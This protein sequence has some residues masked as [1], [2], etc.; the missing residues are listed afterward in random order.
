MADRR[1]DLAARLAAL[2]EAVEVADGRVDADLVAQARA[3]GDKARERLS[4]GPR[5]VVVALGGGTG[6]GKSS[7]FNALAGAALARTGAVRPVTAEATAWVVGESGDADGLLEWLGVPRRHHVEAGPGAPDGL[8]LL[9]LPDHDSV[10][11]GHRLIVDRYVERVDAFVWVV[12]PLKYAQRALFEGYLRRLAGHARVLLVV[13]NRVDE[14]GADARRTVLDDLRHLLEREGLGRARVL[15]T[16]ARTG[17]GIGELRG[18]VAELVAERRAVAQRIGADVTA[19]AE[20]MRRQVGPGWQR[21][22]RGDRLAAALA[23]AAGVD[24]L[25]DA[26]AR[27]YRHDADDASRPL[28]AGRVLQQARRIRNPL[29]RLAPPRGAPLTRAELSPVAVR[30]AVFALAD[31]AAQGLPHPWPARLH[32][33]GQSLAGDLPPAVAKGLDRVDVHDVRRRRWWLPVAVVGTLLEAATLVGLVWLTVLAVLGYLQLPVPGTP[34]LG[35]APWPTVLALGGGVG[36]LVWGVIRRRLVAV[37]AARHRARVLRRLHEAVAAAT[38]ERAA[39]AA[40]RDRRPPPPRRRPVARRRRLTPLPRACE[41]RRRRPP[42][43]RRRG[44]RRAAGVSARALLAPS[45]RLF[46]GRRGPQ[47]RRRRWRGWRAAGGDA[48]VLRGAGHARGAVRAAARRGRGRWQ[49]RAMISADPREQRLAAVLGAYPGLVVAF[50][51]GVDSSLLLAAAADVLG[52]RVT[53]A[54]AVSPSLAD[55]E[56]REAAALAAALGVRH[57]EVLTDEVE[58][59]PYR[60]NDGDRCFHC[61]SALLDALDPIA[62]HFGGATIAVGAITDD[63]GDHRPGQRAAAQ[64]GVVAPLATAGLSKADVRELSRGRGLPTWDKPAAA[65]LASRVVYGLQVTPR[66][67]SRIEAAEEWLRD[68]L[69]RGV[70]LRVRDHGD[71]A[72]IEVARSHLAVVVALGDAL[73]DELTRLGWTY[74]TVDVAGFRSGSLNA[75]LAKG[76][77][78]P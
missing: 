53:A 64:R 26:G 5:A 19:V 6:S 49:T 39:A 7:L 48:D 23:S 27:T 65:C 4:M 17:E 31:G 62:A 76:S 34:R 44:C 29:R 72:R 69:G 38:E 63:L 40:R 37:G 67:L 56:R 58:R 73:H 1:D 59:A 51:G 61:K 36:L 25:A 33:A 8:V 41:G 20:A 3:V 47:D 24:A 50:S 2:S 30:H 45:G 32:A 75:S 12:D 46:V 11:V 14:L 70:D 74:V 54:T 35:D 52:E 10:A 15:A 42:W 16:S 28:V 77:G 66:R 21:D 55:R 22:L 13:L 57:V 71:L 9:D 43:R 60:R 18:V 78:H 68:H